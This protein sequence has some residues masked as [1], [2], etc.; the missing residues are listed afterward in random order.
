[1]R[2]LI[3]IGDTKKNAENPLKCHFFAKFLCFNRT[4]VIYLTKMPRSNSLK[5]TL[6][7]LFKYQVRNA[8]T[9]KNGMVNELTNRLK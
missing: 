2:F 6:L 5:K 7:P 3:Q 1:M 8:H 4:V 9:P